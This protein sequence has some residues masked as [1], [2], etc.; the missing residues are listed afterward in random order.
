MTEHFSFSKRTNWDIGSNDLVKAY[1]QLKGKG[2]SIIDL[3]LSNPTQ[4]GIAYPQESILR[5]FATA[6]NLV[7]EPNA[8][9]LLKAR[10]QVVKYYEERGIL[11]SPEQ[12]LLTSSTSEAYSFIFRLLANVNDRILFPQPS[13]PLF[14]CLTELNDVR[15]GYYPLVYD[16]SWDI[17]FEELRGN[18]DA[19]TKAVVLVNPNNPTGS[20]LRKHDVEDLNVFCKERGLAIICDEVFGDFIFEDRFAYA[21][22]AGNKEVL[23]F[24]LSG[25]SKSMGLPQMKLAWIV[26]NGPVEVVQQALERLEIIADTY[27]SVATPSQ[28]ALE[29][30]STLRGSIQQSIQGRLERNVNFLKEYLTPIKFCELLKVDAGWYAILKI[31]ANLSEDEWCQ[32]FLL[33]DHVYTHPGYFFDFDSEAFIVLSLLPREDQFQEGIRRIL[34]RVEDSLS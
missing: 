13:Y 2:V 9:G 6:K 1:E 19:T 23:T 18:V 28:Q 29:G 3:T 10:Q 20:F 30:W 34:R 25:L 33:K 7:Y 27:L 4:C 31:P 22:L 5:S 26:V 32:E 12:I 11:V 24:T 15:I 21:H 14:Q 8:K 16:K 17:D